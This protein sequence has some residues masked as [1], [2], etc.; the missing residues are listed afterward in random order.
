M[1]IIFLLLTLLF[2]I[3]V[4]YKYPNDSIGTERFERFYDEFEKIVE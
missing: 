1:L 4:K 2:S 3:E